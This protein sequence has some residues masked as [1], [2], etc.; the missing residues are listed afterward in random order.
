[1]DSQMAYAALAI[2]TIIVIDTVLRWRKKQRARG[3]KPFSE[4]RENE[5]SHGFEL[6]P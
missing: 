4:K 3:K 1:M 5:S 2:V 6:L